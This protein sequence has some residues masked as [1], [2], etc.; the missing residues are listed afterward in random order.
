MAEAVRL[1]QQL[2][3]QNNGVEEERRQVR[4]FL[5]RALEASGQV[6]SAV[7][8]YRALSDERSDYR[9]VTDRLDRLSGRRPSGFFPFAGGRRSL[10]KA[11]GRG[12]MQLLRSSS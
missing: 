8:H 11:L 2:W 1:L 3:T 12:W 7:T 9:D 10:V 4:Y 6:E 5:A